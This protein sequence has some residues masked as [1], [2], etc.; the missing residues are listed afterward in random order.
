LDVYLGE[1]RDRVFV[2]SFSVGLGSDNSTPVGRFR[3]M[4]NSKTINP[5]WR[6]PRTGEYFSKD[7]PKNP[8]GEQW[9]GLEGTEE[10][11]KGLLGYGIHG[12]ID[13]GSIG[14]DASLG[15]VRMLPA[16]VA[17]LY[18]MLVEE[19]STVEIV[20]PRRFASSS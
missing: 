13:P 4:K 10:R 3:L 7:D 18:E 12:T 11:T 8:I 20:D 6:N 19:L 17:L 9:M 1:G 16:D 2:R 15:C 14:R 5:N